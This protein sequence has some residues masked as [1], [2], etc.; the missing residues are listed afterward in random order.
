MKAHKHS[1][2]DR[3]PIYVLYS[4]IQ[5]DQSVLRSFSCL[6]AGAAVYGSV[7]GGLEGD[8]CLSAAICAYCR[9][10]F[11]GS[12]AGVLLCVTASLASLGLVQKAF[13]RI[14]FLFACGEDE[15][16]SA[17]L[18]DNRFVNVV[19]FYCCIVVF[20]LEHVCKPLF[21]MMVYF[22]P[23]RIFTAILGFTNALFKLYGHMG[24]R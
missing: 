11:T 15:F 4:T 1:F 8:L 9:E 23:R 19:F 18:A 13:F 24:Q 5:I 6:K 3:S 21:V 7:A 14:E 10:I 20:F 2:G 12:S 22:Y 16:L 17:I